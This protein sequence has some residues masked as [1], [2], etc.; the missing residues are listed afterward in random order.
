MHFV[1]LVFILFFLYKGIISLNNISR[2]V[3]LVVMVMA[4]RS[5]NSDN[6]NSQEKLLILKPHNFISLFNSHATW[7]SLAHLFNRTN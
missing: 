7:D 6:F 2:F 5:P 4:L 1:F 3:F